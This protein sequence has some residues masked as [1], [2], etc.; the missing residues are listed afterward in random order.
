MDKSIL[1]VVVIIAL[2]ALGGYVFFN[3]Q[4]QVPTIDTAISVQDQEIFDD[5]IT[6]ASLS[7]ERPGYVVIHASEDERPGRVLGSSNLFEAGN[8]SNVEVEVSDLLVGENKLFAM[9]HID[10]GDRVYEFPGDDTPARVNG[11]IVV[12]PLTANKV[13]LAPPPEPRPEAQPQPEPMPAAAPVPEPELEP[14]PQVQ[15]VLPKMAMESASNI[16]DSGAT[17]NGSYDTGGDD[18]VLVWF[19]YGLT[20]SL[21]LQTS[22]ISKTAPGSMSAT[23]SD[24]QDNATYYFRAA[25]QNTEGISYG[26]IQNFKTQPKPAPQPQ[27]RAFQID[28]NDGGYTASPSQLVV[29]TG[30]TVQLTFNVL[31]QGTYFGGL[32]FK[33]SAFDTGTILPGSSK[34]VEFVAE[35]DVLFTAYWP[36]SGTTKWSATIKVE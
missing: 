29:N 8:Y 4:Y 28:A 13:A 32:Q 31:S 2:A 7:L 10:D 16:T 34:T 5:R 6:V 20:Q 30:D 26:A 19:E 15:I 12:R 9:V 18:A 35:G 36:N 33:G 23:I 27:T 14:V 25:G 17:L 24:L 1:I 22:Q 11:Q 3:T 21:D